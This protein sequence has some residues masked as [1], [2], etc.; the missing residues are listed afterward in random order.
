M[1]QKIEEEL[2]PDDSV[3]KLL[4]RGERPEGMNF[5]EF[6]IKRKIIQQYIKHKYGTRG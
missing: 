3:I 2:L 5:E 4:M 1:Y 6:K